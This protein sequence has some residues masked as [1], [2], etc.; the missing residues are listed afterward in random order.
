MLGPTP[1]AGDVAAWFGI[2]GNESLFDRVADV[3]EDGGDRPC[4]VLHGLHVLRTPNNED[5]DGEVY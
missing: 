1:P 5:I 4:G 2:A 3:R